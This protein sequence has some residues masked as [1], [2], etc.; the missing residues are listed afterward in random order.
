MENGMFYF[1]HVTWEVSQPIIRE[2]KFKVGKTGSQFLYCLILDGINQNVEHS[3]ELS[4]IHQYSG[5]GY[6]YFYTCEGNRLPVEKWAQLC[7]NAEF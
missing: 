2:R 3:G 7:D 6:A 4:F 1:Y 5:P